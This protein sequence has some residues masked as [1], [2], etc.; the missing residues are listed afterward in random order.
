MILSV[1]GPRPIRLG[2]Y[3]KSVARKLDDFA[4]MEVER[5]VRRAKEQEVGVGFLIGMALGFDQAIARACEFWEVEFVACVPFE[6]QESR[7]PAPVQVEYRRLLKVA[8]KVVVV[9]PGGFS[10]EKMRVRNHYMVD[11][12]H[13]LLA[14]LGHWQ[15]GGTWECVKYAEKM[16]REMTNLW[17]DW[18]TFEYRDGKSSING[19]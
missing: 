13:H 16:G 14:L 4:R 19:D 2:G 15:T 9:S 8:K 12:S 6:G 17:A 7:W 11:N 3:Y 18:L 10:G 5:Q 1:T